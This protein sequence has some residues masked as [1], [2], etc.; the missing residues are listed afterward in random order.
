MDK[1]CGIDSCGGKIEA[2]GLCHTHYERLRKNGT[3]ALRGRSRRPATERFWRHV[4]RSGGPEACWP[5]TGSVDHHGYG[6]F[7]VEPGKLVRTHRFAYALKHGPIPEG[8]H[9]CHHCDNPPCCN[10]AHHFLG[11]V[12]DNIR[13]MWAKGRHTKGGRP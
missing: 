2:K 10:D 5:W 7:R 8:M 3:T 12:A 13:D 6:G 11:T 1:A 9:V 4:D